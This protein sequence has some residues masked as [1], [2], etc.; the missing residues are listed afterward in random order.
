ML[1]GTDG[2]AGILKLENGT[3]F[4][5]AQP[6]LTSKRQGPCRGTLL[7][8]RLVDEAAVERIGRMF[9]LDLQILPFERA[10]ADPSFAQALPALD[11]PSKTVVASLGANVLAATTRLEGFDGRPALLLQARIPRE[12][13]QRSTALLHSLLLALLAVSALASLG[14]LLVLDRNVLARLSALGATIQRIGEVRDLTQRVEVDGQDELASVAAAIN[15]TLAA[16][17]QSQGLLQQKDVRLEATLAELEE[18]RRDLERKVD[19]RTRQ[20]QRAKEE[21]E[22][23]NQVK[24][25]FVANMSHELRTPMTGVI[26]MAELVLRTDLTTDQR[27]SVGIIRTCS[28]SLL[29]IIED[30]LDLSRIEAGRLELMAEPFSL[31]ERVMSVLATLAPAAGAKQLDLV[32]ELTPD[33]PDALV[34][35]PGRL[36]QILINIVGNGLKFSDRGRVALEVALVPNPPRSDPRP[37]DA[38]SDA[39]SVLLHFSVSDTGIGIPVDKQTTLFQPFTQADASYTRRHGGTGLGLAISK[40]LVEHMGGRIWLT[41][42]AG[43]G[44]VVH[45][46]VRLARQVAAPIESD[47]PPFIGLEGARVLVIDGDPV[48]QRLV[49]NALADW[50]MQ[51]ALASSGPE[52]L[53]QHADALEVGD[54]FS[55]VILDRD[56][57]GLDGFDVAARIRQS[58]A[59]GEA[60]LL[61]LLPSVRH[62]DHLKLRQLGVTACLTEPLS[63]N[64]LQS[65]MRVALRQTRWTDTTSS[66]R[67]ATRRVSARRALDI[68]S[69]GGTPPPPVALNRRLRVLLVEDNPV[70]QRV[71]ARMLETHGHRVT[72]TNNGREA[73]DTLAD[74][75][76][77]AIL[78][79]VQMPE[80]GGLETTAAIRARER[81]TGG[82][83]PIV[84]LTAH[85]MYGDAERC[86][87]AGMDAYL[88][89][90]PRTVDLLQTLEATVARWQAGDTEPARAT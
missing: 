87:E 85:A 27:E 67:R 48:R 22:S 6:I 1:P 11:A 33:V 31:R 36:G 10:A 15:S 78:M 40:Q 73:L 45:F 4:F 56:A 71:V 79:D 19:E 13:H 65:S 46:T 59:P 42:E 50:G 75:R 16:L 12:L 35:D 49:A 63:L 89:K 2:H 5:S 8:G 32:H 14:M 66:G 39:A 77:D 3:L 17:E 86:R 57:P 38:P 68:S 9:Y 18:A 41:S 28:E 90:P 80:L 30:V 61:I 7:V 52:G 83:I 21:A 54:P 53:C 20:L 69:A 26:G 72:T 47:V 81:Q 37:A 43:T 34:G 84:A 23:A 58:A 64:E 44:T 88:A 62:R 24:S 29:A 82:H 51:P 76:F 55:A 60:A 25:Q 70:N 74:E